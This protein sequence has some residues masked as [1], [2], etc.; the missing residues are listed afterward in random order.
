MITTLDNFHQSL[1]VKD[2]KDGNKL[3]TMD[4]I[5]INQEAK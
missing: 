5:L 3:T 4:K 1:S 2:S